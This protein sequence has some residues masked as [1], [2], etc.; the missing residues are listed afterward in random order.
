[1]STVSIES[2]MKESREFAPDAEFAARATVGSLEQYRAMYARSLDDPDGFW[3]EVAAELH[4]FTKHHRTVEWVLPHAK[5]FVG[6]TTNLAYN[7]LDRHLSGPRRNKAAIVWE[8]EPGDLRTLTYHQ[9]HREV[10]RFANVLKKLGVRAGDRVAIYMGMVPEIAVAMLACARI[11]A[12]H[13][14]IFGGFAAEAV[15]D[16]VNDARASVVVT[17]DGAYRRGQVVPLKHIVDAAIA[18]CPSVRHTV[19]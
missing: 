2:V 1:M 13:T 8:G 7:C 12:T 10:C 16:R 11:G 19:V 9:L 4:W 3:S 14:V 17:C 18:Q 5:W 6:G 15:R